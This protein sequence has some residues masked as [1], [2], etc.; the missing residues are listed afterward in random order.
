[1]T[2]VAGKQQWAKKQA[3]LFNSALTMITS[4]G[5]AFHEARCSELEFSEQFDQEVVKP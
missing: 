4:G 5:E 2:P 3:L 1:M